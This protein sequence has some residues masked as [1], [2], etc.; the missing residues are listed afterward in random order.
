MYQNTY[1]SHVFLTLHSLI[2]PVIYNYYKH[3][4]PLLVRS[5][6]E[7]MYF[8]SI[9]E[10]ECISVNQSSVLQYK[11]GA[12]LSTGRLYHYRDL[13]L[14]FSRRSKVSKRNA[15]L[16]EFI[17]L[18]L[19]LKKKKK[20]KY[21]Y[22]QDRHIWFDLYSCP[23]E[24]FLVKSAAYMARGFQYSTV[25]FSTVQFLSERLHNHNEPCCKVKQQGVC[26]HAFL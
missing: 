13:L 14:F 8:C 9:Q 12:L 18:H 10:N 1:I 20:A 21:A 17:C 15:I 19:A 6:T 11:Q 3:F 23:Q 22:P 24:S 4:F 5:Q 16:L 7:A 26:V 2:T 25:Q